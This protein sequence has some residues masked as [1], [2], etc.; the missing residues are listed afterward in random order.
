[1]SYV[2]AQLTDSHIGGPTG[3]GERLS[4]AVAG[5]NELGRPADL[6]VLTG[7]N[8]QHGRDDEWEEIK[9]RLSVLHA[10]WVAINGNHDEGVIETAGHRSMQAGPLRLVLMDTSS[11]IFDRRDAKWLEAELSAY[12]SEPT[13]IAM[14][15]PPFDTGIWWMD[16]VGLDGAAHI[17]KIVRAHPQV[18]KIIC[19]HVHRAIQTNWGGCSLWISPSTTVPVASGINLELDTVEE[20]SNEMMAEII[21]R[22]PE[23]LKILAGHVV[24]AIHTNGGRCSLWVAPSTAITVECEIQIDHKPAEI[25]EPPAFSMHV[26][27]NRGFVSHVIPAGPTAEVLPI[28]TNVPNFVD[29]VRSTYAESR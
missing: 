18:L 1:M 20:G 16:G 26:Y 29:W 3:G 12:A 8:T 2:I 14:H 11:G 24:R 21:G 23:V 10:P 9:S 5:I 28:Q 19:G 17:E 15:H 25:A 22:H 27:T 13:I 4:A 7:D 6:V